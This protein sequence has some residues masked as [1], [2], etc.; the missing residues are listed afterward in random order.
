MP[1]VLSQPCAWANVPPGLYRFTVAFTKYAQR[2]SG[3]IGLPGTSSVMMPLAKMPAYNPIGGLATLEMEAGPFV[4][5][6][7]SNTR[8]PSPILGRGASALPA[9]ARLGGVPNK[10]ASIDKPC[11]VSAITFASILL[12][13]NVRG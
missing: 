1:V 4:E 12:Q 5:M 6:R 11:C 8:R 10:M 7:F 3:L 13:S 9:V 2:L